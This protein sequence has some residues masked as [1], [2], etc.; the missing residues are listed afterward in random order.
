MNPM[1]TLLG[2]LLVCA[3]WAV[4]AKFFSPP[5][6]TAKTEARNEASA[7]SFSGAAAQA[8][9]ATQALAAALAL[10][11]AQ[12][13]AVETCL[14]TERKA[15]AL[16][17]TAAAAAEAHHLSVQALHQVFTLAQRETYAAL[18]HLP[19]CTYQLAAPAARLEH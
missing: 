14:L 2:V 16:A 15:Q 4:Q 10:S 9:R 19:C 6:R 5:S 7:P 17:N 11:T 8:H 13:Q 3:P 12:Q 1:R 18:G